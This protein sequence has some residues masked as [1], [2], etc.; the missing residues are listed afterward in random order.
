MISPIDPL[1]P[2]EVFRTPIMI[3]RFT[4]GFYFNGVWQEGSQIVLSTVLITGNV[5]NITYNNVILTPIPFTTDVPTT[6]RLIQIA[7]EAQANVDQVDISSDYL[8]I[9]IVPLEPNLSV[10]NSFTV[11]SGASQPTI[12]IFNSP[13]LINATASVQPTKGKEVLLVPEGR[14]D[15]ETYKMY[16]STQIEAVTTQNP[17]Q[18][19]V[20]KGPF[21]GI[22]FECI[23]VLDWQNNSNF[24]IVN[25][26]KYIC[27][28]LQPLPGVL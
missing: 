5:V 13:L 22:V 24:N 8:T 21:T 27:M 18:V 26:Y 15:Q 11:T 16:T 25:H 6:M 2:F 4:Q 3:R 1:S 12:T 20:L 9:T 23:E 14:R 7:L 17:D 19:T 10:V 28:R